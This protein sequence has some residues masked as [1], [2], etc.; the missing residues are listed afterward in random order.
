MHGRNLEH[1][2][3]LA[4]ETYTLLQKEDG[5]REDTSRARLSAGK[6]AARQGE[7]QE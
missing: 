1:A 3:D 4:I 5:T 7:N 6:K 2:K